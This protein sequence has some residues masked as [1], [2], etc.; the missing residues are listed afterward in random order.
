MSCS[1]FIGTKMWDLNRVTLPGNSY[2][3]RQLILCGLT[4]LHS[5]QPKLWS[6]GRSVC[7][8]VN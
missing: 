7:D 4:L 1:F 3:I 6:F 8:R 5:E 2:R